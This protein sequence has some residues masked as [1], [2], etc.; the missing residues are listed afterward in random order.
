MMESLS[1]TFERINDELTYQLFYGFLEAFEYIGRE[2][3]QSL[4]RL[5]LIGLKECNNL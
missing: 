4:G 5:G 3:I 2:V 1:I